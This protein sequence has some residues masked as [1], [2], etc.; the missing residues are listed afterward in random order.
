MIHPD[1]IV[2]LGMDGFDALV[3]CLP[4]G[5]QTYHTATKD[6]DIWEPYGVDNPSIYSSLTKTTSITRI[7]RVYGQ[8]EWYDVYFK[9]YDHFVTVTKDEL[10]PI[11]IKHTMAFS[12]NTLTKFSVMQSTITDVRKMKERQ[13][14]VI[15]DKFDSLIVAD[16]FNAWKPLV[17]RSA[18]TSN[19][20][21]RLITGS[22]LYHSNGILML[23]CEPGN[24]LYWF[25]KENVNSILE[26]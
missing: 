14:L 22:G 12:D 24:M 15:T 26:E 2:H 1:T 5:L 9:E 13:S 19:C 25:T 3:D 8:F 16:K 10:F 6:G 17:R 4:A 21:Y 11:I 20:A 7:E 18:K 23:A